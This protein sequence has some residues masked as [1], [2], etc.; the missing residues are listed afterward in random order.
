MEKSDEERYTLMQ[1]KL[2]VVL[3][4]TGKWG[5]PI[6]AI[7]G[8][9]YGISQLNLDYSGINRQIIERTKNSSEKFFSEVKNSEEVCFNS[10]TYRPMRC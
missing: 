10:L 5:L 7:T 3:K 1:R 6:I 4:N 2:Q 9:V 8:I